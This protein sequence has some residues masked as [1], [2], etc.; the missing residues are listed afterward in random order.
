MKCSNLKKI[1]LKI[2][3]KK[4][5]IGMNDKGRKVKSHFL[6]NKEISSV[7]KKFDVYRKLYVNI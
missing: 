3:V 7:T 2:L 5:E 6:F 4:E 1:N